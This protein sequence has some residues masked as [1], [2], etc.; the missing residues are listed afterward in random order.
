M[1]DKERGELVAYRLEKAKKTLQEV[2]VLFGNQLWNTA[3]NRLYYACY[4]A[5]SAILAKEKIM[6]QT[7][8]GTRQMFGLHFVKTGLVDKE[9]GKFY[10]DLFDKR[11][12]GDY[13]DFIDLKEEDVLSFWE[14]AKKLLLTIEKLSTN[15]S[16]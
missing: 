13:D 8:S 1:N 9:L 4:Y 10:S 2:D 15:P 5:V 11:Q 7:H 14:P 12:T 6:A 3:I 16:P